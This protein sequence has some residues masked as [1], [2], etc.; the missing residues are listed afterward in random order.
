MLKHVFN[1]YKISHQKSSNFMSQLYHF[2]GYVKYEITY[3]N[4]Y[5]K[6]SS[7]SDNSDEKIINDNNEYYD[8]YDEILDNNEL[9]DE[10]I[11]INSLEKARP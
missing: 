10:L 8:I 6:L 11:N 2:T 5:P 7:T 9:I 3:Y 1:K 4:K